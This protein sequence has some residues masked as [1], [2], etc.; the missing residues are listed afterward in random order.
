MILNPVGGEAGPIKGSDQLILLGRVFLQSG[1]TL[2]TIPP[3]TPSKPQ[4]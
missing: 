2:P 4:A 3:I 1:Q